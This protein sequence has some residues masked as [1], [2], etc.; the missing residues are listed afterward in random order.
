MMIALYSPFAYSMHIMEGLL[1][2]FWAIAWSVLSLPVIIIGLASI[3]KKV[4]LNP[5]FKLLLAMV[6]AF[7]FLVSSLKLPSVAGS[8]SHLTGVGLGAIMFGPSA[9]SIVGLVVLIFQ[10]LLLAHG[11]IATLGANVFSMG[12]A[13]PFL[14]YAVFVLLRKKIKAPLGVAV[15]SA[16]FLGDLFTYVITSF[17][18]AFAF[19]AEVGGIMASLAK[20][21]SI[22]AVTQIPLA[23]VEGLLTVI[24]INLLVKN[25]HDEMLELGVINE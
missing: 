23:V 10:A 3:K 8:C 2:P 15:F 1:P 16:A 18:L 12:I 25:S 6:T 4:A 17:E 22:F 20:F 14:A 24:I 5:R 11:G 7:A 19:P 9:M 21:M 13:G